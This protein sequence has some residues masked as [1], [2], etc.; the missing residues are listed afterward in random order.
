MASESHFVE[1]KAAEFRCFHGSRPDQ[2]DSSTHRQSGASL[3]AWELLTWFES[4][5]LQRAFCLSQVKCHSTT[6]SHCFNLLSSRSVFSEHD[7]YEMS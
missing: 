3:F 5:S 2:P 6:L 7:G 1:L 4:C